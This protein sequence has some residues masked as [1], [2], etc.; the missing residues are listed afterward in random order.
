MRK[1]I[2][3]LAVLGLSL[4]LLGQQTVLI[5]ESASLTND[6]GTA[7]SFPF[8][9]ADPGRQIVYLYGAENFL[10][11]GIAGPILITGLRARPNETFGNSN[12][13]S[14]NTLRCELSTS[15]VTVATAPPA[16]ST[17]LVPYSSLIGSD[18]TAIYDGALT[19]GA[20]DGSLTPP[21]SAEPFNIDIDTNGPGGTGSSFLYDPRDGDL[22]IY[23]VSSGVLDV[24][25]TPQTDAIQFPASNGGIA[26]Y[27]NNSPANSS[28]AAVRQFSA[29]VFDVTFVQPTLV[30]DIQADVTTGASPLAVNFTD[31][32]FSIGTG[33]PVS[34][35]W[36]FDGDGLVDANLA[37]G[38]SV[39]FT[40]TNCG[41]FS[42]VFSSFSGAGNVSGIADLTVEVD[43]IN[44]QILGL[45]LEIGGGTPVNLLA[46]PI[47]GA[48]YAWDFESDGIVDATDSS[49]T[50]TFTRDA[51]ETVTLTVT[52]DCRT[53]TATRQIRVVASSVLAPGGS[54]LFPFSA[55]STNY[56]DLDVTNPNGIL[57]EG[58]YH[59]TNL[60]LQT[61][62]FDLYQLNSPLTTTAGNFS[63]GDYTLIATASAVSPNST[64]E[65]SFFVDVPDFY[66]APGRHGLAIVVR[67]G[68]NS[69]YESSI[70]DTAVSP[71]V[72]LIQTGAAGGTFGPPSTSFQD[73]WAGGFA[74]QPLT[75][76]RADF[77]ADVTV[78]SSPLAVNFTDTSV[79]LPGS[80]IVSRSWDLNSDGVIDSTVQ[81]P[82]FTYPSCGDF[83]VTLVV[84]AFDGATFQVSSSTMTKPGFIEVDPLEAS[85]TTGVE[86]QLG[87]VAQNTPVPFTFTGTAGAQNAWDF[88]GNGTTDSM[89]P[90]PT[91][92]Y[93]A[94]GTFTATLTTTLGCRT[95]I[96]TQT[97]EVVGGILEAPS[98]TNF[99]S[100][101]S[102]PDVAYFDLNVR[103]QGGITITDMLARSHRPG[104][105][106]G[107]EVW[108]ILNQSVVG[109]YD[110]A[111]FTLLG[112]GQFTPQAREELNRVNVSDFALPLGTHGI[113]VVHR[114]I[115]GSDAGHTWWS[116]NSGLMTSDG[117]IEITP[118]GSD[119]NFD[120]QTSN[121]GITS[122]TR[123]FAG[124]VIYAPGGSLPAQGV[125]QKFANGCS[126]SIGPL[127]L[128]P[129]TNPVLGNPFTIRAENIE[130]AAIIHVG[131][132]N[133]F[134]PSL[135]LALPFKLGPFFQTAPDCLWNVSREF[136]FPIGMP[137]AND[138]VTA[139]VPGNPNPAFL[140]LTLYFQAFVFDAGALNGIAASDA[141]FAT[142]G[143]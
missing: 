51:I 5:P 91:F 113:A 56:A 16:S 125:V 99:N 9:N 17:N 101:S 105:L 103:N 50:H 8:D 4:P 38:D 79:A 119:T 27:F 118:R 19:I 78:G 53:E 128:D 49:V 12:G 106:H 10:N 32:T 44:A 57:V 94:A 28:S 100:F 89:A 60:P 43:P 48:S 92:S 136:I 138:V 117:T 104:Q 52:R 59:K 72:T 26:R 115:N 22:C 70:G 63:P 140:G 130:S 126:G 7:T 15:Q 142:I 55:S 66:L 21:G 64:S 134:A 122:N 62:R 25:E 46:G 2:P 87:I 40:F 6:G 137:D 121:T 111:N 107:Y 110:V 127:T 67:E 112:S 30:P 81:N 77:T 58:F 71:D 120:S 143:L 98:G 35:D 82:S 33:G 45:P 34:T 47:P 69:V 90:S 68:N 83:D 11:K 73:A 141:W 61:C 86:D 54:P 65:P 124:G 102:A 23:L 132:S 93:P 24:S 133:S 135:G 108:G 139:T 114:D 84:L 37:P 14:I 116:N 74:Y 95:L 109:N 131:A 75:D 42:P 13:S 76:L 129:D 88:D 1:L 123:S 31:R 97:I 18:N 20:V 80:S 85:F 3:S 29:L 41:D 96:N 39:A 36:D